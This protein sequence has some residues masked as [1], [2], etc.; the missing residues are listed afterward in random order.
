MEE[1]YFTTITIAA[2]VIFLYFLKICFDLIVDILN[3]TKKEIDNLK[4]DIKNLQSKIEK[5]KKEIIGIRNDLE[6]Y[7]NIRTYNKDDEFL[8]DK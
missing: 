8:Q 6:D 3:N 5:N 1:L 2:Y 7:L 4:N